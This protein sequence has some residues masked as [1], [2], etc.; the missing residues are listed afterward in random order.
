ME[1]KTIISDLELE[2]GFHLIKFDDNTISLVNIVSFEITKE[3][4]QEL[5]DDESEK[6]TSK[7][8]KKKEKSAKKEE[9][10]TDEEPYTWE[11]LLKMG[12][13]EL[14]ELCKEND[15]DTD[16]DNFDEDEKDEMADFGKEIA[17]E[18]DIEVPAERGR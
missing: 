5:L 7:A 6:A 17:E 2:N 12:Y 9:P 18:I 11:D 8:E 14:E 13:K 15:L 10:V 4:I 1:G 3:E 16:P